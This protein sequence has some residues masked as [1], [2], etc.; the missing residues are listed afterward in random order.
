MEQ[1]TSGLRKE[2]AQGDLKTF[3]GG[4]ESDCI[5]SQWPVAVKGNIF[6]F[7][8]EKLQFLFYAKVKLTFSYYGF[9]LQQMCQFLLAAARLT[10]ASCVTSLSSLDF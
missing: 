2:L 3:F 1:H 5:N 10:L 9:C 8:I 6:F 7:L 4:L